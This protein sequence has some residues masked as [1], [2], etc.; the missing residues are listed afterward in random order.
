MTQRTATPIGRRIMACLLLAASTSNL[1]CDGK[2][3]AATPR[4]PSTSAG[5]TADTVR[6]AVIGGMT[7]T[8]LWQGISKR[9][10]Q[11]SGIRV[12]IVATGP[13]QIIA[14]PFRRG[15]VDLITMHASDTIIN[16]VA[17]GDGENPQPWLRNDLLWV[18]PREDPAK[19]KG[20]TDGTAAL[21]KIVQSKSK[22]LV[23]QSLGTNEVMHDLLSSGELELDLESTLTLPSDRH[24]QLLQRAAE[25]NAY[26]IVG[27][28]PFLNGKIAS[29]GLEI[30][31]QGDPRM[32]RPYLVVV[33]E[34]SKCAPASHRAACRLAAFLRAPETQQWIAEFG[35]GEL[36]DQPI[37]FPVN[38]PTP[39]ASPVK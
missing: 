5:E 13:K 15:E 22:L 8:G 18:G 36:D 32:R 7:D 25:E 33:R 9:F 17:D 11:A 26:A 34:Q 1:A 10:T 14:E 16:L 23:H 37:F 24:R 28:I 3:D 21:A 31:V 30:M 29:G 12:E 38:V 39:S 6:C 27:R 20:M 4:S 19:I 2:H 35:R